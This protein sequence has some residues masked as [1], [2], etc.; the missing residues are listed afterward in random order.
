MHRIIYILFLL[1]SVRLIAQSPDKTVHAFPA[2]S[3]NP[4]FPGWYADPEAAIFDSTYWVY[5][6]YS[7]KYDE[8]VFFD[9]FSS[10]DLVQW[11]K[12][13]HILDTSAIRWAHRA[14]WAPA[15]TKK[16]GKYFFFFAANDIQNDS[17]L[18]GIGVA[19]SNH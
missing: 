9:A 8:Q 19:V 7:H 16:D 5:P 4:I 15:I 2:Q 18:G 14:M 17:A 1:Y 11:T 6:T 10:P 12:H 3:G 13:P